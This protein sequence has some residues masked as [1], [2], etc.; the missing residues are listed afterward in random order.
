MAQPEHEG[1]GYPSG[2]QPEQPALLPPDL[3]DFLR[4]QDI[5]CLMQAT[6]QGTAFVVKL[7]S[8]ELQSIAGTVPIGLR[9]ELY[10]HPAAPV[11][12]T[13]LTIYDQPANPLALE[14]FTNISD[15]D[16]REDFAA[17]A[18]QDQLLLLCYD[19][20]LAHRLSKVVAHPPDPTV[21]QV[22]ER[23]QQL[24]AAIPTARFDFDAAKRAVMEGTSL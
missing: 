21:D 5:A 1:H 9:H 4:T 17:L 7:P 20:A 22:V 2:S 14:T 19:E 11:I 6:D 16:Q 8:R 10:D 24:A 13:V 18:T 12:R 15:D 23:A 3:A